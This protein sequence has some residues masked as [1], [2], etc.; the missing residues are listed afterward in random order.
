MCVR[1]FGTK[2]FKFN[3][4]KCLW[5]LT[6]STHVLKFHF[7]VF[8]S[9]FLS[10]VNSSLN[11]LN[12]LK[13]KYSNLQIFFE[14]Y[15]LFLL[16]K[17]SLW[18]V[19]FHLIHEHYHL[20]PETIIKTVSHSFS[21]L[22]KRCNA[23]IPW[24]LIIHSYLHFRYFPQSSLRKGTQ[25]MIWQMLSFHKNSLGAFE[26]TY[27]RIL[28]LLFMSVIRLGESSTTCM[29]MEITVNPNDDLFPFFL[30][31]LCSHLNLL[32]AA[33]ASASK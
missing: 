3:Q 22:G 28:L 31:S 2:S 24:K 4:F 30:L 5:I 12:P 14:S 17:Y 10:S 19:K 8:K 7:A 29:F 23:M 16:R 18:H 9:I 33:T 32:H 13:L 11:H 25:M 27:Q 6:L 21:L 26:P 20:S 15:V 1:L